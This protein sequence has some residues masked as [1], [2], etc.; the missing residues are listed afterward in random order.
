M[1]KL[2]VQSI[3]DYVEEHIEEPVSLD[4]IASRIGYS[5]FYLHKLFYIYTGMRIMDYVRK[6]KLEYSLQ[7]LKSEN[8]ILDIAVKYSF[9]TD[10]TYSRAF[11]NVYGISPSKYR[12]NACVLTPKLIFNQLGGIKMLLYLSEAEEVTVDKMYA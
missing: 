10:S 3:I 6:R 2:Y 11:K 1:K 9:S 8:S 12:K 4:L 7:D 5:K